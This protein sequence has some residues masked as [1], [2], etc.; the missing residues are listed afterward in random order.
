MDH[1]ARQAEINER[2]SS[3]KKD[4][5]GLEKHWTEEKE[6]VGK[7]LDLRTRLLV[8]KAVPAQP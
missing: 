4:L 2:L 6:L 5:A 7:I 1:Q 3:E 8:G